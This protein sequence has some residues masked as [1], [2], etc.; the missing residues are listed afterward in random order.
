MITITPL[1]YNEPSHNT[2]LVQ[3]M[4]QY[5]N[6]ISG[7]TTF[8]DN[9]KGSLVP[10]L[11][12]R[13]NITVVL[14]LAHTTPVGFAIAIEGFSTF[15]C[16]PL[17]N[18]HDLFVTPQYRQS[19]I[20]KQLLETLESD[21]QKRGCTKLTLEVLEKNIPALTLY[22]TLGYQPYTQNSALGRALFYHKTLS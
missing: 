14:A 9:I 13:P 15:A 11:S 2:A 21:A 16:R 12:R 10:E 18:V 20:A 19:G 5:K 3:L 7:T 17:L 4:E 6:E 22:E 8:D 1:D